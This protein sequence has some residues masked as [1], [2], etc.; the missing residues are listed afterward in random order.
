MTRIAAPQPICAQ[1]STRAVQF[2]RESAQ[3][4]GWSDRSLQAIVSMSSEGTVGLRTTAKY[5]MHQNRGI[6]PFVMWWAE[7]RTIPMS[8]GSGG[9]SFVRAKGVGTPGW[10]TLPGGVRKWREQRWRHPGLKPKNFLESALSRAIEDSKPELQKMLMGT[11]TGVGSG[12]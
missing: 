6:R 7:G 4:M 5:V 12:Y 10:V 2:A 3:S 8:N 1:V 9:V 11:L